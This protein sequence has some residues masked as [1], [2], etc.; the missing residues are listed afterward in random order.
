MPRRRRAPCP[1]RAQARKGRASRARLRKVWASRV[2]SFDEYVGEL[3]CEDEVVHHVYNIA[4]SGVNAY[5]PWVTFL[6]DAISFA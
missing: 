5:P 4:R 2:G 6:V 1:R 3:V